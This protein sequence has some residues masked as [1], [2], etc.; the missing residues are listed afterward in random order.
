MVTLF[1]T[2]SQDMCSNLSVII[3][4]LILDKSLTDKLSRMIHSYRANISSV[5]TLDGRGTDTAVRKK[6]K[7]VETGC[8]WILKI[9]AVG[10]TGDKPMGGYYYYKE[11][12]DEI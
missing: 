8:M 7:M 11:K 6:K 1:D 9:T 5:S 10:P 3:H 2:Y 4:G 12:K